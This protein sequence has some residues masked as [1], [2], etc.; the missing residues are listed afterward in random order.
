MRKVESRKEEE[1]MQRNNG[2]LSVDKG[3][4]IRHRPRKGL[5]DHGKGRSPVGWTV[6]PLALALVLCLAVAVEAGMVYGRVY[7]AEE[8]FRPGDTFLL[9]R[10]DGSVIEVKTDESRGYSVIIEP[11]VYKVEFIKDGNVWESFIRS[12]SGPIRQDIHLE[13]R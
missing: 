3:A 1:M 13:R 7:G 11:G 12:F 8:A 10:G 4:G 6:I 2:P 9:K 5:N